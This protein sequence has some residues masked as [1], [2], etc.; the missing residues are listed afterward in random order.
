MT[1]QSPRRSVAERSRSADACPTLLTRQLRK[2]LRARMTQAN[3]LHPRAQQL[4]QQRLSPGATR[5]MRFRLMNQLH[6]PSITS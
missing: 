2:A 4:S 3:L 6:H 1:G 5:F